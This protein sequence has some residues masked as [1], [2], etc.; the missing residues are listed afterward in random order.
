LIAALKRWFSFAK[1]VK[2]VLNKIKEKSWYVI[3]NQ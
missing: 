2:N 3:F 1:F